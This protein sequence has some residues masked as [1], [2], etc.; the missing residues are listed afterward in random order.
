LQAHP[1][2]HQVAAWLKKFANDAIWLFQTFLQNQHPS[3][4]LHH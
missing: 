1:S 4:L 3:V 2:Q